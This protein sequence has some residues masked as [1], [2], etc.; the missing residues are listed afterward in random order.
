MSKDLKDELQEYYDDKKLSQSQLNRLKI[1]QESNS[2][3]SWFNKS[4][5]AGVSLA[6]ILLVIYLIIPKAPL[7]ERIASEVSYNHLKNMPSEIISNNYT[8]ID[9]YLD[10]LDFKVIHPKQLNKN[11][12]LIGARYCSIQGKIAAQMQYKDKHTNKRFTLYQFKLSKELKESLSQSLIT[13]DDIKV[14]IW[15]EDN[16][17]FALA[18]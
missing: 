6:S 13:K 17:G 9:T 8:A 1:T 14:D 18:E 4:I 5:L 2:F 3:S 11:L 12:I 7:L 16:L 15:T 10:R